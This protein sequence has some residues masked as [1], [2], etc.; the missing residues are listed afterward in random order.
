MVF[1]VENLGRLHEIPLRLQGAPQFVR[2]GPW[3][4]E[5]I[6]SG[7]VEQ[8]ELVRFYTLDRMKSPPGAYPSLTKTVGQGARARRGH[9]GQGEK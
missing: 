3:V 4:T 6:G 9:L 2:L 5:K 7:A 1:H 8:A